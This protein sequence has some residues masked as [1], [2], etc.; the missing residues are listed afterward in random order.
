MK[1]NPFARYYV[2]E[3]QQHYIKYENPVENVYY[4]KKTTNFFRKF[5]V[6]ESKLTLLI[7]SSGFGV[8]LVRGRT[9]FPKPAAKTIALS[10]IYLLNTT[11]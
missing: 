2:S 11:Q 3:K 9:L 1:I 5:K 8:V 4:N 10:I 6:F 7:F